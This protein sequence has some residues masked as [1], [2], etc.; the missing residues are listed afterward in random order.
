ML[1]I[2]GEKIANRRSSCRRSVIDIAITSR[3]PFMIYSYR[4]SL[5]RQADFMHREVPKSVLTHYC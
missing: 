1:H 5:T 4:Y 2:V 3:L